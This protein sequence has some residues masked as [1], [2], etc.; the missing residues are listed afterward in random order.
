M[1]EQVVYLGVDVAKAYLDAA[2][3]S[4]KRRLP[5][6]GTGHRELINWIKQMETNV[7]VI[8]EPSGGYERMLIQGRVGA[9]VKV[10]LVQA[11]RVRQ[12][13]RAAGILP[14]ADSLDAALLCALRQA[15]P[16]QTLTAAN[17]QPEPLRG[18]QAPRRLLR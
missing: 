18:P 6:D 9:Q 10:S 14:N 17:A 16:P 13:A 4:E 8:C 7:Q 12:F 2:M 3:G 11:N 15:M 1:K 5:N